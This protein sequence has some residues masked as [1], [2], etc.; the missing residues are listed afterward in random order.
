MSPR[1]CANPGCRCA[2]LSQYDD[3]CS[4]ECARGETSRLLADACPCWHGPC[5]VGPFAVSRER[6]R[7]QQMTIRGTSTRLE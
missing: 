3:C 7:S 2:A 6:L 5:V 4:P 1:T